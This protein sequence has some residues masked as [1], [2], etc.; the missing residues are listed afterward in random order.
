[1]ENSAVEVLNLMEVMENTSYKNQ[2]DFDDFGNLAVYSKT[3]KEIDLLMDN[4][5][6]VTYGGDDFNFILITPFMNI[7]Y[8]DSLKFAENLTVSCIKNWRLPT[9]KE[10]EKIY[11]MFDKQNI[12]YK[13]TVN[14]G[15]AFWTSD[16]KM[17]TNDKS[18][19]NG[20]C[21]MHDYIAKKSYATPIGYFGDLLL[22]CKGSIK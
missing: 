6:Y 12:L 2:Y 16:V 8:K 13:L 4:L 19:L 7:T 21:F 18:N 15:D 5:H 9:L 11:Y 10:I 14:H 22:V 3:N 1:M 20:V 17:F